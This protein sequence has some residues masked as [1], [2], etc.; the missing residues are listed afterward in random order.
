ME[1]IAWLNIRLLESRATHVLHFFK[2]LL[3]TRADFARLFDA[4]V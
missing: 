3:I 2:Y 4:H 1:L